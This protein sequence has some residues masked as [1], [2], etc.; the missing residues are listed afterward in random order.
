[1]HDRATSYRLR[2]RTGKFIRDW[3]DLLSFWAFRTPWLRIRVTVF[4][5]RM[6]EGYQCPRC[7]RVEY[8][9]G[10]YCGGCGGKWDV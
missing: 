6:L 2:A 7:A 8:E 4:R 3:Q 10:N 1:M 5:R 9:I